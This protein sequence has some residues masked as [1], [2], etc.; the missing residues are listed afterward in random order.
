MDKLIKNYED[1]TCA[2]PDVIEGRMMCDGDC[3][4]CVWHREVDKI[5]IFVEKND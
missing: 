3:T 5:K 1:W 2:N 4:F